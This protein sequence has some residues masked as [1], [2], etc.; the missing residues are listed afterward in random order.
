D[1]GGALSAKPAAG[2]ARAARAARAHQGGAR[3]HRVDALQ[4]DRRVHAGSLGRA[5]PDHTDALRA[6]PHH[7]P[8][9]GGDGGEPRGR[10]VLRRRCGGGQDRRSRAPRSDS[11]TAPRGPR[12]RGAAV[13]AG[14]AH[15]DAYL[16]YLAVERGYSRHT[17]DN[18]GRDLRR[19]IEFLGKR[20]I[21]DPTRARENDL[22]E[23]LLELAKQGLVARSRAR[24]LAAVRGF[25]RFLVR[26]GVTAENPT[27]LIA[28]P[29]PG[30]RLPEF[31]TVEEV[32]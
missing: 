1:G 24:L 15:V 11:A 3:P 10:R 26:E 21:E 28:L 19:F 2:D 8:V 29:K 5:L 14:D 23:L 25:Y 31:L 20:G 6:R 13:S 17:L 4:R 18:Y 9:Q 12:A 22:V 27:A 32:D 30:R 16:S 7:R